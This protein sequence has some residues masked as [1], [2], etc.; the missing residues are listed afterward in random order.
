MSGKNV[1]GVENEPS[2]SQGRFW[3]YHKDAMATVDA[4][5]AKL[6]GLTVL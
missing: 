3:G 1:E 6:E 5:E 4:E 2:F